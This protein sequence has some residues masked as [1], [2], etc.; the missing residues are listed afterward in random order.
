MRVYAVLADILRDA[1]NAEAESFFREVVAA[2][3][4][5]EHADDLYNAGLKR[6]GIELYQESLTHFADAYCIQSRLAVQLMELGLTDAAAD[7]YTRAFELM[8]D[9]FG[10]VESHCFG[11]EGAF[12]GQLAQSIADEVFQRM[13]INQPNNP[14]VHYLL[15]YLRSSQQR[16][17][18][19]AE[20]YTRATELDP[21]YLNAWAKLNTL[22]REMQFS[23]ERQDAI[24]LAMLRLDPLGRHS[25]PSLESVTDL[26]ALWSQ[27]ESTIQLRWP[28]AESLFTLTAAARRIEEEADVI[29]DDYAGGYSSYSSYSYSG[30]GTAKRPAGV[31]MVRHS[32]FRIVSQLL[33]RESYYY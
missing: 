28:R 32:V 25:N 6:R 29:S 9:S 26:T 2:I 24:I 7:H 23:P 33:Q 12:S 30:V 13:L 18:E 14:R 20:H 1:G 8:P 27:L 31:L 15:G 16:Y 22:S 10:R 17:E 19:A 21:E 3:R 4:L 5:A 11:C